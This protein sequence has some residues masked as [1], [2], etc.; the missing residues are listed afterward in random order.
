MITNHT[1]VCIGLDGKRIKMCGH[2]QS[3]TRLHK[4]FFK[5]NE[6]VG[7]YSY[8]SLSITFNYDI[9]IKKNKKNAAGTFEP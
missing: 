8:S 3:N 6:K 1:T 7:L 9:L 2:G 4:Y 5:L